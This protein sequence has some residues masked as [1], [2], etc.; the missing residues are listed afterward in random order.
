MKFIVGF[1]LSLFLLVPITAHAQASAPIGF[2]AGQPIAAPVADGMTLAPQAN[3]VQDPVLVPPSWLQSAIIQLKSVPVVGPIVVKVLQWLAVISTIL[4]ALCA[5]L[6]ASIRALIPVLNLAQLSA[7]ADKVAAFQNGK[8]IYWL[9]Y[10]SMMNAQ[11][12]D[13]KP[14]LI[15]AKVA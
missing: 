15:D 5:F 8:V 1:I 9:K 2:T 6:L 10:F 12:P 4:T 11:K 13:E 7:I 3:V 14:T